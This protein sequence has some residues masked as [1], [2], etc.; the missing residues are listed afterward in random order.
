VLPGT[1][2]TLLTTGY[3]PTLDIGFQYGAGLRPLYLPGRALTLAGR[4]ACGGGLPVATMVCA[5]AVATSTGGHS[6]TRDVQVVLRLEDVR[7]AHR[8]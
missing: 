6:H 1:F 2:F 5:M 7:A 4:A 8:N 3:G